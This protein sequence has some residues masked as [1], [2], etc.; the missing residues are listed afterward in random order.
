MLWLIHFRGW[1]DEAK[2]IS[3]YHWGVEVTLTPSRI[4]L[5]FGLRT[6][7]SGAQEPRLEGVGSPNEVLRSA[8]CKGSALTL[9]LFQDPEIIS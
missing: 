5:F 2:A 7:P 3:W 9:E 8:V 4:L 1:P 6:T